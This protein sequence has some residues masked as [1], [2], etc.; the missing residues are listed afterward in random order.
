MDLSKEEA[1]EEL[2]A[3]EESITAHEAQMSIHKKMIKREQFLKRLVVREIET[4]K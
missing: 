3:I 1:N 2:K 4:F